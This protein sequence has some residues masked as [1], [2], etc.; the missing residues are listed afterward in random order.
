MPSERLTFPGAS[1]EMLAARF[2]RPEGDLRATAL[3]AH[4]FTC[5]KDLKAVR[6]ISRALADRGIGVLAFDFT[7]LGESEGDFADTN[8]SSN[9]DDLEAAARFMGGGVGAPS[10]LVGHSLGGAAVL[11]VAHRLPSVRGVCTIAAPSDP[12]HLVPKLEQAAPGIASA[13]EARAVIAGREFRIRRQLLDDLESH[14]LLDLVSSLG[15]PLLIFHSP[16]DRVVGIEHA[17]AI[18]RAARHPRSFISLDD[19]DHLLLHD[20]R[21]G[22][23]VGAMLATWATRYIAREAA[24]PAGADSTSA[25]PGEREV[26]VAGGPSGYA[27]QITVGRHHL[28]AD[29]PVEVGGTDTGPNPYDLLLAALGACT[30]ITLRMYADRKE[31]SLEGVR[32]RLRHRKIHARDCENCES[33]SGYVDRIERELEFLGPLDDAQRKRLLEIADKCPVHRTLHSEV[34]VDTRE[35]HQDRA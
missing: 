32:A 26:V 20:K 18:Y 11:A 13:D 28:T 31:W 6:H 3:F 30:T 10:L 34:L 9:L 25:P 15:R 1:G 19:A 23:F 16:V 22:E 35:R 7:G 8:F 24:E 29:E 2:E 4:C 21:D 14:R 5:S 17:A 27:Q 12:G 33:S